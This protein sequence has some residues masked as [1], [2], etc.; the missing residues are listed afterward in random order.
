MN[1]LRL[2]LAVDF[3][4]FS[5]FVLMSSTGFILAF[6]LPPG[7]GRLVGQGT[8]WRAGERVL[9]WTLLASTA[10]VLGGWAL[11]AVGLLPAGL[12]LFRIPVM[13]VGA[14][15]GVMLGAAG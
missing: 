6:L 14:A 15:A 2:N 1:R 7:S 3:L 10:L 8:G 5:A 13:G 11:H 4:A 9:S 12:A